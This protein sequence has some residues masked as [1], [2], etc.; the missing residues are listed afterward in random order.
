[1]KKLKSN[2][3]SGAVTASILFVGITCSTA[4]MAQSDSVA[5]TLGEIVVTANNSGELSPRQV[6]TSV[7]VLAQDLIEKQ[8]VHSN[9]ELLNQVPGVLISDFFGKGIGH[10]TVSM[11]GFNAEGTLNAVKLLIDG[12][13]SN[14]NDGNTYYIDMV[15]RLDIEAIEVVKGTN[16]PRYGLHNIAGNVNLVTRQGGNYTQGRATIGSFGTTGF[17]VAKGIENDSATQNY[18]LGHQKTSG[19][20]EHSDAEAT[21][22]SGKWFVKSGAGQSQLGLIVRHM[23]NQAREPGYL[24][25]GQFDANPWQ[26]AHNSLTNR[27]DRQ[28]TQ[29][30]LK[31]ESA[32]SHQ[33]F[34]SGQVYVNELHD[35]RFVTFSPSPEQRRL[36]DEKQVGASVNATY[37]VG[38]TSVGDMVLVGGIDTER[39]DNVNFRSDATGT[40]RNHQYALNTVGGFVQAVIKPIRSLT[41]TPAYRVDKVGGTGVVGPTATVN[42]T[43]T[44]PINDYGFIK[45]PKLSAAYALSQHLTVYGNG[46]RTFQIGTGRNAY[47]QTIGVDSI[48]SVNDGW[49]VGLKFRPNPGLDGRIA[50]WKQTASNEAVTQ[51]GSAAN[52]VTNLGKTRRDGV[53]L[54]MNARWTNALLLW[55]GLSF[56]KAEILS[57]GR[58]VDHVPNTIYSLGLDYRIHQDWRVGSSITGQSSYF[59]NS[60]RMEKT[61]AYTMVNAS[62]VYKLNQIT[63]IDFQVRNLTN[64]LYPYI[65]DN[66]N[67]ATNYPVPNAPR[68]VHAG[69]HFKL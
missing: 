55:G 4:S 65:Y 57:T 69:I 66:G 60:N 17:Q 42:A 5:L 58:E 68:S 16:D 50:I 40:I 33:L 6:L 64:H 30:A 27:N 56:Q 49:E 32:P 53:D 62:A 11:R 19:F 35:N 7:S 52:A 54:E 37:R 67:T 23:D 46:G 31:A 28:A 34:V 44:Y 2:T 10:G 12:V 13:P 43:T 3:P 14:A 22:F 20:R 39:Q 41:V 59:I 24:S 47:Q 61:G 9:Y 36:L 1:M 29:V 51:L 18:A 26:V 48:P 8:P 15:P 63:E 21:H 45:Q 38:D 25:Q